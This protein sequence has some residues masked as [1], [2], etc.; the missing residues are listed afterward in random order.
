[1]TALVDTHTSTI[2]LHSVPWTDYKNVPDWSSQGALDTYFTDNYTD[3]LYNMT[4][5]RPDTFYDIQMDINTFMSKHINYMTFDNGNGRQ[6]AFLKNPRFISLNTTR[7]DVVVDV[8]TTYLHKHNYAGIVERAHVDRWVNATTPIYYFGDQENIGTPVVNKVVSY[9]QPCVWVAVYCSEWPSGFEPEFT[10]IPRH[11]GGSLN[12]L[13]LYLIPI[14]IK[15]GLSPGTSDF[16]VATI[17]N[18]NGE[19]RLCGYLSESNLFKSEN[20]YSIQLL[21]FVPFSY[22]IQAGTDAVININTKLE[23]KFVNLSVGTS[24]PQVHAIAVSN[25]EGTTRGG[26]FNKYPDNSIPGTLPTPSTPASWRYE[27]RLWSAPYF[28]CVLSNFE[29]ACEVDPALIEGNLIDWD[30]ILSLGADDYATRL[31]VS[32]Y[33]GDNSATYKTLTNT[34]PLRLSWATD[35]FYNYMVQ[36]SA[37]IGL[38]IAMNTVSSTL[39]MLNAIPSKKSFR[40]A[41]AQATLGAVTDVAQ[42][43]TQMLSEPLNLLATASDAEKWPKNVNSS[44][45]N[46]GIMLVGHQNRITCAYIQANEYVLETKGSEFIQN[47]YEINRLVT[48]FDYRSRYWFNYVKYASC[49]CTSNSWLVPEHKEILENIYK[50]G[51]RIWHY[52]NGFSQ[53]G[54]YNLDNT[55]V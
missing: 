7:V 9:S 38:K 14:L 31:Q 24:Y 17:V 47:G 35:K 44:S 3:L 10:D 36:N 50:A 34:A 16:S 40:A 33:S 43:S 29:Q 18:L 23:G 12:P 39:N 46:P 27:T 41:P 25:M 19:R 2:R 6:Y 13:K 1:M 15:E 37:Q 8:W 48:N 42:S 49:V 22:S 30:M 4:I 54:K 45:G 21:P 51:V 32:N 26:S 28:T 11:L 5:V 52:R 20:I 55:E 53:F